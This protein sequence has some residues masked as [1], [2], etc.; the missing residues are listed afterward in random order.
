[1]DFAETN[2]ADAFITDNH[3]PSLTKKKPGSTPIS[4][5]DTLSTI[6]F[7]V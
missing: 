7:G 1:M 3:A 5:D 2:V 4:V 6:P